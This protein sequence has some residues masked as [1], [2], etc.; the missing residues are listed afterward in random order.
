MIR[1]DARLIYPASLAS[2][3]ADRREFSNIVRPHIRL[4]HDKG[5]LVGFSALRAVTE[6]LIELS[7]SGHGC[8]ITA[9]DLR[10]RVKPGG[11]REIQVERAIVGYLGLVVCIQKVGD[12]QAR[13]DLWNTIL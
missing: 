10:Y 3:L 2:N 6:C 8:F 12:I 5:R 9:L 1:I 13:L 7:L 4:N 11:K